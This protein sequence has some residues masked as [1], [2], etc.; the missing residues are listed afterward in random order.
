[1]YSI[2]YKVKGQDLLPI[3]SIFP[4]VPAFNIK[5]PTNNKTNMYDSDFITYNN[6]VSFFS[7]RLWRKQSFGPYCLGKGV[8]WQRVSTR[9]VPWWRWGQRSGYNPGTPCTA[10]T[11]SRCGKPRRQKEE[12]YS[13]PLLYTSF[14]LH[15]ISILVFYSS[16]LHLWSLRR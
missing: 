7:F 15:Y 5:S 16:V 11:A 3:V 10:V 2:V 1:M 14:I 13:S 8:Y 9:W 12:G 6:K 4:L